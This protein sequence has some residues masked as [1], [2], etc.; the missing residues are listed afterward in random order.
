MH[1]L[2]IILLSPLELPDKLPEAL[3]QHLIAIQH[4]LC[5]TPPL[6][7]DTTRGWTYIV[8]SGYENWEIILYIQEVAVV[9]VGG[10]KAKDN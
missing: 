8:A 2:S 5:L 3:W 6:G 1:H 7:G 9:K 4:T 10:N